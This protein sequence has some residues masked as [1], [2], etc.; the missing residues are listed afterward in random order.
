LKFALLPH[1]CSN[2]FGG[3]FLLIQSLSVEER[4]QLVDEIQKL[5]TA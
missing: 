4:A 1:F 2:T 3:K 5:N